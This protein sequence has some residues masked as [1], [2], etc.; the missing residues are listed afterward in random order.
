MLYPVFV[1][2]NVDSRRVALRSLTTSSEGSGEIGR[3]ELSRLWYHF[4]SSHRA[5]LIGRARDKAIPVSYRLSVRRDISVEVRV[6]S[7]NA[8]VRR[9]KSGARN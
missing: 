8:A 7:S 6:M 1:A 9:I 4:L 2:V 5:H 3:V